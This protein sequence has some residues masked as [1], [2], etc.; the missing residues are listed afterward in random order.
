M[1]VSK[2]TIPQR[3]AET[4]VIDTVAN[5]ATPAD[6]VFTAVTLA[7]KIYTIRMDNSAVNAVSYLKSQFATAYNVNN[8]PTLRLYAPANTI[9][10]YVWPEGWPTGGMSTGF[11]F[12][13]TSTAAGT[14]AQS[15]P[16]GTGLLKVTILAGT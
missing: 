10:E 4:L 8:Y 11:S 13:G 7:D 5:A 12:I 3:L 2:A 6:N 14:G 1:T 9:V 15:D 16:T